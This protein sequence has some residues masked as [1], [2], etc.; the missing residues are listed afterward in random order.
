MVNNSETSSQQG[1][2][3]KEFASD[4]LKEFIAYVYA[5]NG[6]GIT[7][8]IVV[9]YTGS[10]FPNLFQSVHNELLVCCAILSI[11][12]AIGIGKGEYKIHRRLLVVDCKQEEIIYSSNSCLRKFS[13]VSFLIGNG[14]MLIPL[15]GELH[16]ALLPAFI[17]ATCVFGSATWFVLCNNES[18]EIDSC[19]PFLYGALIAIVGL[20]AFGICN[21]CFGTFHH[22]VSL[23][24][25]IPIFT[26][27]LAVDTRK[28]IELYKEGQPDHLGCSTEIYADFMNVFVRFL[29]IISGIQKREEEDS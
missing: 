15:V 25:G 6:I 8:T 19:A 11:C 23:Y 4:G 22:I 20:S 24:G 17:A 16:D 9:A 21:S 28:A 3:T 7:A 12:G 27:L 5:M 18:S 29:V 13:Y 2:R 1:K 14:G 26:V 10:C